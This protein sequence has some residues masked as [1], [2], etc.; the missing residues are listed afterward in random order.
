MTYFAYIHAEQEEARLRAEMHAIARAAYRIEHA[1]Y[2][3]EN[4]ARDKAYLKAWKLVEIEQKEDWATTVACMSDS[5]RAEWL[6]GLHKEQQ[7]EWE[8]ARDARKRDL[9]GEF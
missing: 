2:V 6:E 8:M 5:E 4:K 1:K 9:R 3:Q 7:E